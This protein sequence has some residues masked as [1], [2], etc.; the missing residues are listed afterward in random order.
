MAKSRID[1]GALVAAAGVLRAVVGGGVTAV[2]RVVSTGVSVATRDD[3]G[4]DCG[5][6]DSYSMAG[7]PR[8]K[9]ER[10]WLSSVSADCVVSEP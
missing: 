8:F 2:R 5:A 9:T 6:G 3:G 1:R 7:F 10:S 4:I